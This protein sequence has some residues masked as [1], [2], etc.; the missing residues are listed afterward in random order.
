MPV[1]YHQYEDRNSFQSTP[2][3]VYDTSSAGFETII[4]WLWVCTGFEPQPYD[5]VVCTRF[6][7]Q[8]YDCVVCTR[9]KPHLYS[10]DSVED[11]NHSLMIM[12]H[13]LCPLGHSANIILVKVHF[14]FKH[15]PI[16]FCTVYQPICLLYFSSNFISTTSIWRWYLLKKSH[17]CRFCHQQ[18]INDKN[19][20]N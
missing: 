1:W 17:L 12:N 16:Y 19:T 18:F 9:F 2:Q 8:P 5:C 3:V 15:L 20:K 14:D 6:E 11:L 10:C 4:L 13:A 7:P